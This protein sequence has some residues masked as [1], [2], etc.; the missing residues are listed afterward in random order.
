MNKARYPYSIHA[1]GVF[2]DKF[3]EGSGSYN[4][5]TSHIGGSIPP[6]GNY[7]YIWEV[8]ERAG[9]GERDHSS[10]LWLYHSHVSTMDPN[11]GLVGPM[12]ITRAN[13]ADE[14]GR[15]LDVAKEFVLL[16]TVFDENES[17]YLD[18][19]IDYYCTDPHGVEKNNSNFILANKKHAING[20]IFGTIPGL[21]MSLGEHVRWHVAAIGDE[22]DIHTPHWHGTATIMHGIRDDVIDLM[23]S[24]M[25]TVDMISDA[26][27]VWLFHCHVN[28]HLVTG[29]Q[30]LYT[31]DQST[32]N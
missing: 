10:I 7:T 23:P 15:P 20:Y 2:Y 25:R 28:D 19:N 6:G 8:P 16:L 14:Q 24:T 9:P 30:G 12:I 18:L 1:H 22:I 21:K 27:G 11:T 29:M 4:D 26:Q 13:R 32:T 5:G 17:P 3:H 31:V